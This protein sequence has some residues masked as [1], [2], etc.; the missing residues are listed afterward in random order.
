MHVLQLLSSLDGNSK[1]VFPFDSFQG[2]ELACHVIYQ[3]ALRAVDAS[4]MVKPTDQC[5][6]WRQK[7]ECYGSENCP[8]AKHGGVLSPEKLEY[9]AQTSVLTNAWRARPYCRVRAKFYTIEGAPSTNCSDCEVH[10]FLNQL[11]PYPVCGAGS[12][13]S[14]CT[15][16]PLEPNPE[17]APG[18]H[19]P[20]R[21]H[22]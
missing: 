17:F 10:C 16:F 6:S 3:Q 11:W 12:S 7:Q 9:C 8:T 13:D 2:P 5:A 18:E 14:D 19:K 22:C 4:V 20:F 15:T 1:H 21:Y